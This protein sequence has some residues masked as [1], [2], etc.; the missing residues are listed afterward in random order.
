HV[1]LENERVRD[2]VSLLR[3]GA[4][5]EF[6]QLMNASHQS[7]KI[8]YEVSCPELDLMTGLAGEQPG[9]LGSR[10]TGAGFGGCTV[11]LV[12]KGCIAEFVSGV[13]QGYLKETGRFPEIYVCGTSDGAGLVQ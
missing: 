2:S 9:V 6:G 4:L 11:S 13:E 5:E 10:M 8:D 1:I 3:S 7:L 12:R